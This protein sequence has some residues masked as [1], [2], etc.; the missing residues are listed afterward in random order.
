MV[1]D[2]DGVGGT[3]GTE[4]ATQGS[5]GGRGGV[6]AN[7]DRESGDALG[8]RL[9]KLVCLPLDPVGLV[10]YRFTHRLFT[11]ASCVYGSRQTI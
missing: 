9:A 3:A 2:F 1:A 11:Q 5:K 8:A 6:D 10:K 7:A 4:D